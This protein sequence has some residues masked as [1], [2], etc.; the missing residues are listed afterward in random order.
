M[1]LGL[2]KWL[3]FSLLACIWG[4]SFILMKRGL[5]SFDF[6]EV[7]LIRVVTASVVTLAFTFPAL[8]EFRR[9]DLPWLIIVGL[10][11]N[12]LPYLLFPLSV[13]HVDSSVVGILNALV[14][15][16]T[17]IIGL[18]FFGARTNRNQVIGIVTG[19]FGALWLIAPWQA[20][21]GSSE[22]VY[23]A[24]PVLAT[25]QYAIAINVIGQKLSHLSTNAIT[26][27]GFMTIFPP[28]L[29][30]L[31]GFTDFT[32]DL[33]ATEGAWTS[34]FYLCILGVV[35]TAIAVILFNKLIKMTTPIFASSITYCIPVV[36]MLWGVYDGEQLALRHLLGVGLILWGVY[37]VNSN[38][39]RKAA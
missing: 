38:K 37:L 13:A 30:G 6:V 16:F 12:G 7:G 24:L 34:L 11:G 26:L 3:I 10:F 21:L 17:V 19:L 23:T 29:I 33:S 15:L 2:R 39:R 28:A 31:F 35:G 32:T 4:S 14:P 18:M 5:L 1:S 27:L 8:K 22:W 20:D 25:V 9:A 36:A